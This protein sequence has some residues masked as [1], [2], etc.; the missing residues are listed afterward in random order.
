MDAFDDMIHSEINRAVNAIEPAADLW[1]RVQHGLT[2]RP[3]FRP[4]LAVG[5]AAVVMLAGA[6]VALPAPRALATSLANLV[7]HV[8]GVQYTVG[9]HS[10]G[11]FTAKVPRQEVNL[12]AQSPKLQPVTAVVSDPGLHFTG[13]A[14]Q[15]PEEAS[16]ALQGSADHWRVPAWLPADLPVRVDMFSKPTES[17]RSV[18]MVLGD[19]AGA[20]IFI[21]EL[22]PAPNALDILSGDGAKQVALGGL[23][24]LQVQQGDGV[25]Y[26]FKRDGVQFRVEGPGRLADSVRRVAESLAN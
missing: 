24:A 16:K 1:S 9:D 21:W 11:P 13:V 23:Q 6:T 3:R 26:Y 5:A 10:K 8:A 12:S 25:S 22:A 2:G 15:F 4:V 17:Q 7:F 14:G 19:Q 18:S 20:S